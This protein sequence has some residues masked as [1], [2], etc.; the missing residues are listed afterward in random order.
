MATV[1]RR[2]NRWMGIY[3]NNE[4]AQRSAGTYDSREEALRRACAEEART[5]KSRNPAGFRPTSFA[6]AGSGDVSPENAAALLDDLLPHDPEEGVSAIG[7]IFRPARVTRDDPGMLAAVEWLEKE[8][9][10][11][12]VTAT[13]DAVQA[14]MIRREAGDNVILVVLWPAEPSEEEQHIVLRARL[15]GIKILNLSAA[16]AELT[17]VPYAGDD[18][19]DRLEELL[20]S[21]DAR[22]IL[23]EFI[24]RI[25]E[26]SIAK[27][28][29]DRGAARQVPRPARELPGNGDAGNPGTEIF[30][31]LIRDRGKTAYFKNEDGMYRR[32]DGKPRRGETRVLLSQEEIDALAAEKKIR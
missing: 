18:G 32:A 7:K 31:A 14:L 5:R 1:R 24:R 25:V 21:G 28:G 23:E 27:M 15:E 10:P 6:F 11:H 3:E 17:W 9:G 8:F 12:R 2:G 19:T 20:P 26:D 13:E 4:G 16:L 30:D 29:L 22:T